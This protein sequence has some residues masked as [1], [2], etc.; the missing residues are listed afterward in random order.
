MKMN[1]GKV[2]SNAQRV[3][4]RMDKVRKY[5]AGQMKWLAGGTFSAIK[6]TA[7]R[8]YRGGQHKIAVARAREEARCVYY[9]QF[10]SDRLVKMYLLSEHMLH[11]GTIKRVME[12]RGYQYDSRR[13]RFVPHEPVKVREQMALDMKRRGEM[14]TYEAVE[15]EV[16]KQ[17][18]L[19]NP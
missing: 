9:R 12:E 15:A 14:D 5:N 17:R 8:I 7:S 6:K 16:F 1:W 3:A 10:P 19:K 2:R 4:V 11:M 13:D 18:G